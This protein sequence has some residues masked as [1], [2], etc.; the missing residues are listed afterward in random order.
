MS[1]NI[2]VQR[3][4]AFCFGLILF[5]A[6]GIAAG[7]DVTGIK[8]LLD[9]D[10]QVDK[11]AAV[12]Y[13]GGKVYFCCDSCAADFKSKMNDTNSELLIK[14]NHQLVLTGQFSQTAC[15]LTGRPA[16]DKTVD[17]GGVKVGLCC[18]G[19]ESKLNKAVDLSAKAKLVFTNTAF[20]KGFAAAKPTVKL[21]NVKC[22]LMPKKNVKEDV[23]VDY[24]DHKVYFCC[25]SCVKRF[26]KDTAKYETQG[27]QHLVVTEQVKQTACPISGTAVKDD[28]S[29]EVNGSTVKFCCGK[30]KAKVEAASDSEKAE[31][32]FG[33]DAFAKGFK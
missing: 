3:L 32:V 1:T 26:S 11:A 28:Q 24:G 10:A 7:Q 14:A 31:L 29:T 15:P 21:D 5:G 9:G 6:A 19:C 18:A 27:N 22:F 23:S 13:R 16:A 30:C 8:C 20:E 17:V 33:K 2:L 12:D 4:L 25:K